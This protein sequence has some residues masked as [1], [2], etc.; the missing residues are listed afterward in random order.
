[1]R[2]VHHLS[3]IDWIRLGEDPAGGGKGNARKPIT[4]EGLTPAFSAEL[5]RM[6]PH[7]NSSEHMEPYSHLL[8]FL[9]GE[10]E[11]TVEDEVH[12]VGAGSVA[13]IRAG[14]F[15]SVRNL[16]DDELVAIAIYDPPR[17]RGEAEAA[18]H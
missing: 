12:K 4:D 8:Y 5:V 7:K 13:Q 2:V 11:V 16:G 18:K 10:G 3:D 17:S 14:M 9:S 6:A 15:H 1:M